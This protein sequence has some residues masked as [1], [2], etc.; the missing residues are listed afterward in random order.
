MSARSCGLG[1]RAVVLASCAMLLAGGIWKTPGLG[2]WLLSAIIAI[3]VVV[4]P[5]IAALLYLTPTIL[6]QR[7]DHPQ[8]RAIVAVNLFFGWTLVGWALALGWSIVARK[9]PALDA[10]RKVGIREAAV[11]PTAVK[12]G[13]DRVL[14]R[15]TSLGVR[16]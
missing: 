8:R 13:V 2:S 9:S 3:F 6:A 10:G 12:D 1:A 5:G 11:S 15:P 7:R 14:R 4:S 16:A